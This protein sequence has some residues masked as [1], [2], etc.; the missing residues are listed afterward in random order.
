MTYEELQAAYQTLQ[1]ENASLKLQLNELTFLQK[2]VSFA[3]PEAERK[4]QQEVSQK[5]AIL[6]AI[7]DHIFIMNKEGVYIDHQANEKD[8]YSNLENIGTNI[9]EGQLPTEII[10]QIIDHNQRAFETGEVQL[11]EYALNTPIGINYYES[12]AIKYSENLVIRLV[13]DITARKKTEVRIK[14]AETYKRVILK[15]IPDMILLMNEKGDFTDL[16]G[17]YENT[18]AFSYALGSNIAQAQ[19]PQSIK[20]IWLQDNQIALETGK[21]QFSEYKL[22]IGEQVFHYESRTVRY[23][24]KQALKIIRDISKKKQAEERSIAEESRK[25]AILQAISDM[26]F[27]M[28]ERGDY[29]DFSGGYGKVF[30]DSQTIIGSNIK[31]S[32]MPQEVIQLLL[33]SN[34]KVLQTGKTVSLEYNLT[35]NNEIHYYESRAVRYAQNQILR[36]VRDIT[37]HKKEQHEN[38]HLIAELQMINE[39]LIS[40]EEEIRQTLEHTVELKNEIER[41]EI[42]YK[43][44]LKASPDVV[45]CISNKHTIEFI[46]LPYGTAEQEQ[47][48]IGTSFITLIKEQEAKQKAQE[49]LEY[50]FATGNTIS[51]QILHYP[52]E[53]FGIRHYETYFSPIQ[54]NGKII[55]VYNV[56]RDI[57]ESKIAENR[58]K[59]ISRNLQTT[60]DNSLQSTILVDTEGK[61]ILA[62]AKTIQKIYQ[63]FGWKLTIGTHIL[64]YIPEDLKK[65]F[66]RNFANA[67]KGQTIRTERKVKTLTG[68]RWTE[69]M[70][71]PVVDE[72]QQVTAVVVGQMDITE[73]KETEEHLRKINEELI[74]Q[75]KQLAHYSYVVSHHLRSPVATILGLVNLLEMEKYQDTSLQQWLEMLQT[76]V[77]KLDNVVKDLNV[78]LSETQIVSEDKQVIHFE[79]VLVPILENLRTQIQQCRANIQYDFG[80]NPTIV[81]SKTFIH[82]LLSNLL[83]NAIK[84]RRKNSVPSIFI[85]TSTAN[86]F[87]CISIRDNGLGIDIATQKENLFKLYKRF[88]PNI[89]G[90]GINLYIL[91]TQVEM[92]G[93]KIEVESEVN[94]GTTFKIYLPI[95]KEA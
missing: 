13:R 15:V 86:K 32:K 87:I 45:V 6:K 92:Q 1:N 68:N 12:R 73:R 29:M 52:N 25:N 72:Q 77:T 67:K 95:N 57:T 56:S 40:S 91:K 79:E 64:Q 63:Y 70:Y 3:L 85:Q 48:L 76:S 61:V 26:I 33:D 80:Q 54:S 93:G 17:N 59:E 11:I 94:I 4:V 60:I 42:Y 37:E 24:Q 84:F 58:I 16:R 55:S 38:K 31:D 88:H 62:D 39:E 51:Y 81:A 74:N 19:V 34:K 22:E 78:I 10:K 53:A 71:A 21:I 90:K 23:T 47:K 8:W 43:T 83:T 27:V 49:A 69:V 36:I 89:D 9:K 28:N 50:V 2:E 5:N 66:I 35:I 46:H 30:I 14:L 41:R 7:P 82:H 18:M 65:G 20:N 44:L 75:N